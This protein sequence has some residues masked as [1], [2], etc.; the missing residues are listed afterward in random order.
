[1]AHRRGKS[2][3]IFHTEC[4]MSPILKYAVPVVLTLALQPAQA[5]VLGSWSWAETNVVLTQPDLD[6]IKAALDQTSAQQAT[7]YVGVLE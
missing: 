1:M 5:Q 6:M 4:T 3:R 2:S 7:R